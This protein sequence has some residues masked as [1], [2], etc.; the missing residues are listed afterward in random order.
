MLGWIYS[1]GIPGKL[2]SNQ[3]R[4]TEL[5]S[6]ATAKGDPM[7]KYD[8]AQTYEQ[9]WDVPQDLAKAKAF[10]E[11][12]A[13]RAYAAPSTSG[14]S[15][16][17]QITVYYTSGERMVAA[18]GWRT[19]VVF[20]DA[21]KRSKTPERL[22]ERGVEKVRSSREPGAVEEECTFAPRRVTVHRNVKPVASPKSKVIAQHYRPEILQEFG[23]PKKKPQPLHKQQ[24]KS[25]TVQIYK[26]V[27]VI[28]RTEKLT[29]LCVPPLGSHIR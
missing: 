25:T 20:P 16:A 15:A 13:R 18:P 24:R 1:Q 5:W 6:R 2:R 7:S 29:F 27:L 11:Q 9:G 17:G 28:D 4:A 21:P 23:Q 22:Y 3:A 8:L 26:Y 14:G 19:V 10:F 12:A